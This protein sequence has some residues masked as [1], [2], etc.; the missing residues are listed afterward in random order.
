MG[1]QRVGHDWATELNWVDLCLIIEIRPAEQIHRISR[2]KK[3]QWSTSTGL[4]DVFCKE[5]GGKYSRLCGSHAVSNATYPAPP[6][7]CESS[8]KWYFSLCGCVPIKLIC[9][10]RL[11]APVCQFLYLSVYAKLCCA[12]K[13]S[14]N[15][16][17]WQMWVFI[18]LLI[19]HRSHKSGVILLHRMKALVWRAVV[20]S[21]W[22]LAA[23]VVMGQEKLA[24][25]LVL[26]ASFW[27]SHISLIHFIS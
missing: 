5:P 1:S 7:W 26:V 17:G 22:N 18:F 11:L 23:V 15:P 24:R 16:S 27:K 6:L 3:S 10:N 21:R 8:C 4:A 12:N 20:A 13:Q 9:E 14:L 2:F 25:M 19:L